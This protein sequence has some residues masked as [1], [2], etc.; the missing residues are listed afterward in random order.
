MGNLKVRK[1]AER[2]R[3][4]IA[5]F[6]SQLER[7]QPRRSQSPFEELSLHGPY[8][9]LPS[10]RLTESL[11]TG[12]LDFGGKFSVFNIKF[13]LTEYNSAIFFLLRFFFADFS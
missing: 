10:Y 5:F 8:R 4:E 3:D 7:R 6:D 2:N 13:Y 12:S 1:T 11:T 9:R